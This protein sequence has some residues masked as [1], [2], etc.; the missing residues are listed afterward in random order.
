MLAKK[1]YLSEQGVR[2]TITLQHNY[3]DA[4]DR[5]R[6]EM[7]LPV[8]L[9]VPLSSEID[10]FTDLPN[11]IT[12][13][14]HAALFLEEMKRCLMR[15]SAPEVAGVVLAKL[16]VA[17][18]DDDSLTIEWIYNYFRSF[19]LFDKAEGDFYGHTVVDSESQS[20]RNDYQRMS[21]DEYPRVAEA[22]VHFALL[23]AAGGGFGER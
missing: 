2:K 21:V 11:T 6:V 10:I 19:Y 1:S 13:N 5:S 17:E 14:R 18:Q 3:S 12:E 9:S 23:M 15:L 16:R 22:E 8:N 4:I 20:Y 7:T